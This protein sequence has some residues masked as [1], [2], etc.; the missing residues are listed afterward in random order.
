MK[1]TDVNSSAYIYSSKEINHKDPKFKIGDIVR[2]TK[3]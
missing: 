2:I 1:P 3:Y